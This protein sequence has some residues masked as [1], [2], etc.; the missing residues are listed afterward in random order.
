MYDMATPLQNAANLR[1]AQKSTGP[2]TAEGKARSS[3]N[4]L[5]HGFNS[6]LLFIDGEDPEQ[7]YKL[8]AELHDEFQPAT[9]SEQVLLE[10][11]AQ[12][13][14][15]S[16]RACRLQ[17][18]ALNTA[19]VPGYAPYDLAMYIRYQQSS[20]RAFYKAH[21]ELLSAQKERKK[22][23]IGFEPQTAAEPAPAPPTPEP[24]APTPSEQPDF[25]AFEDQLKG[26]I[27]DPDG[28][29]FRRIIQKL[30]STSKAA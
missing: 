14:W 28:T 17:S 7:F 12:N 6:S 8:L 26:I 18:R 11:M 2:K 15:L 1:N 25:E 19:C 4:R 3:R 5:S 20:D 13:Q 10:R 30:N 23:E 21:T 16:L 9:A 29:S 24:S 22:S 27:K